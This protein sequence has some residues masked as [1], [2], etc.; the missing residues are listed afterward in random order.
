M[1]VSQLLSRFHLFW[2]DRD[3][4]LPAGLAEDAVIAAAQDRSLRVVGLRSSTRRRTDLPPSLIVG[5]GNIDD[6]ALV[7]AL[8]RLGEALAVSGGG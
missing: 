4:R 1:G 8:P 5:F 6:E 2:P 7:D 3:L